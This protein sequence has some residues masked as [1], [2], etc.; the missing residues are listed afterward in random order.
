MINIR[1]N[2]FETNSSSSHSLVVFKE[3]NAAADNE[4]WRLGDDGKLYFFSQN[5]LEF[6]R[7]PFELL[8][9]WY[10]RLCYAIASC[11]DRIGEIEAACYRNLPGLTAIEYPKDRWNGKDTP[12]YGYVDHQSAGLLES[13]LNQN[14]ITFD[15]F[16]FND[17][18]MVVIDGDEYGIFDTLRQLPT[19][20]Q[21]KVEVIYD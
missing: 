9:T 19:W 13:F 18:Y 11:S 17:K 2:V 12:Y 14:N 3:S 6:G 21:D 1:N 10:R 5:E 20:N 16:I 15:E 8:T 7:S 4:L